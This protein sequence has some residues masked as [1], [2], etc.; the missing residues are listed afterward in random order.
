[1]ILAFPPLSI[2]YSLN[3]T[4]LSRI[5][6]QMHYFYPPPPI[7]S[8]QHE[9]KQDEQKTMIQMGKERQLDLM[10]F[11]PKPRNRKSGHSLESKDVQCNCD[12]W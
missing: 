6:T 8:L 2:Q 10:L 3:L 1:M 4:V 7:Q 12:V 11:D 9:L 5:A